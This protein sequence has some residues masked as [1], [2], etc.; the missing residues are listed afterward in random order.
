M[1]DPLLR[2][3]EKDGRLP[4]VELRVQ[5][6]NGPGEARRPPRTLTRFLS[7]EFD[8]SLLVPVDTFSFTFAVPD[9][10]RPFS[11]YF[12]EGDLVQ[13][14]CDNVVLSTGIIDSVEVDVDA[15]NGERITVQ[16][17][18]LLSQLEDQDAISANSDPVFARS[19]AIEAVFKLL[20]S[21]TRIQRLRVQDAPTRAY[22]FATEPGETK[23]SALARYMEPLNV[24]AWMDPDGT[25]VI[26]RPNMLQEPRG[27]L[28]LDKGRRESNVLAMKAVYAA[29]L[30]PNIFL[31]VWVGQETVQARVAKS[32]QLLNA[33]VGPARLLRLG[34]QLR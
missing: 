22:L 1:T 6:L 4:G 25:L 16:G 29:A 14:A 5:P 8:S 26:G 9:D 13:L 33:S 19:A 17:R 2:R 3:L 7:Y 10:P 24:L 31:P 28:V 12:R 15:R 11:A 32:Q 27:T 34:H 20:T 21:S 30:V 23:L 18:D